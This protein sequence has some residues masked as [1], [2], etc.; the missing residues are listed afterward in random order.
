MN[1]SYE[2]EQFEARVAEE[3]AN[4][5]EYMGWLA[6]LSNG[7]LKRRIRGLLEV[8]CFKL[9]AN[10][11]GC[12]SVDSTTRSA[13]IAFLGANGHGPND[14]AWLREV[15]RRLSPDVDHPALTASERNGGGL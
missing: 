3:A 7:G 4:A 1:K 11:A 2:Q 8:E 10:I 14:A 5:T 6:Q 15:R 13:A 12:I 9:V